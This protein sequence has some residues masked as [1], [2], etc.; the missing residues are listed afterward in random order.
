MPSNKQAGVICHQYPINILETIRVMDKHNCFV[1]NDG[2]KLI[3]A[4]LKSSLRSI[5]VHYSDRGHQKGRGEYANTGITNKATELAHY[6]SRDVAKALI[7]G[8]S[9]ASLPLFAPLCLR[10]RYVPFSPFYFLMPRPAAKPLS[11]G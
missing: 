1:V 7:R 11:H 6:C 5:I 8:D 9:P 4:E 10:L 3:I 2:R